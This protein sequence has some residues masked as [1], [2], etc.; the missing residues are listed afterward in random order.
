ARH[1]QAQG[2]SQPQGVIPS[3]DSH[4]A[5]AAWSQQSAQQATAP[6]AW[7][8]QPSQQPLPQSAQA[9][10]PGGNR[11]PVGSDAQTASAPLPV[12]TPGQ[13]QQL[14][15][16]DATAANGSFADPAARQF[17]SADAAQHPR[18]A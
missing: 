2:P 4:L 12:V 3:Y 7:S 5:Q 1:Q 15:R 14:S 13:R 18:A 9:V 6:Q 10:E 16:A 11:A 17:A 8:Q